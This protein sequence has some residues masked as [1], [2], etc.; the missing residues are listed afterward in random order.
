MADYAEELLRIAGRLLARRAGQRGK[1]PAARVRRS[2]S[3]SYYALFHFLTEQAST[4]LIGSDN[5]LRLRRHALARTFTHSGLKLALDKVKGVNV[6]VGVEPFLRP[7]G[8]TG[9]AASPNFVRSMAKAFLDAQ[10]MRLD[11]DYDM[12]ASLS[13]AD[14][15]SLRARIRHAIRDWSK[16]R[17]PQDRDFK[18]ALCMLMLLGGR[19]R[20][21]T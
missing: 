3:T 2:I 1:L 4:R 18:H 21:E 6:D 12:A 9:R 11:A 10:A 19:L 8:A 13:E 5:G 16:A 14:A 15:R 17:S 20:K 7:V